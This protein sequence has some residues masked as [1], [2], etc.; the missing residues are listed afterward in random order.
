MI[1]MLQKIRWTKTTNSLMTPLSRRVAIAEV[2]ATKT[3]G[4]A[5]LSIGVVGKGMVMQ[6]AA[7]TMAVA[8][9]LDAVI[10]VEGDLHMAT[11]APRLA[12]PCQMLAWMS[13][14]NHKVR[15]VDML[16]LLYVA[17][18]ELTI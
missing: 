7:L 2:I 17:Q 5:Q 16:F 9:A 1:E 14:R 12:V 15:R 8:M 6:D 18:P 3:V 13:S 11:A 10:L 4:A